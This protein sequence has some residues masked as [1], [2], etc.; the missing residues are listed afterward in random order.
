MKPIKVLLTACGCPG[1]S[2]LIRMLRQNGERELRIVGVDMDPEAI[3][4]FL[5]DD[6]YTVPPVAE[7][8]AYLE[9]ML[10]LVRQER[11]DVLFPESSLEVPVLAR[12]TGEIETLGARVL[13]SSPQSIDL[14][15]DKY[16]MYQALRQKTDIPLPAYCWPKNLEEFIRQAHELG[17]PERPVCFKPHVGKGSRG[18]RIIDPAVSRRDQL[19]DQKPN[20][21]YMSLAEFQTI[22]ED[23]PHFPR[24]MLMEYLPEAETTTDSLCLEGQE[25]LTAVK[26]VEQARWGVIVRGELLHRPDL[27]GYT[28]AIL[29]IIRLSYCVNLQFRG[30]KLIEIN[31]RVSSFIYQPDLILPYLAI[32]LALDEITPQEIQA[33]QADIA[34]GRRMIRYMDQVFWQQ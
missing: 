10:A 33:R 1:A 20:S 11:P 25:L 26:S 14:A 30:Q 16:Q 13:I 8:E 12:H 15:N 21:R 5:A 17:Y 7:Q 18:F 32:K 28:R 19:L 23:D 31:P 3:G 22:F 9:R 2:T 27:V 4:R 24:L 6:F 29:Q 34:I